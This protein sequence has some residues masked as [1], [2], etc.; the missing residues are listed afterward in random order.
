MKK[1]LSIFLIC[2]VPALV[3]HG[4]E[5]RLTLERIFSD[6]EFLPD[7]L[8]PTKWVDGGD[9][10][11]TLEPSPTHRGYVELVRYE[12][13]SGAREVL[14][15]TS[16]LVPERGEEPIYIEDYSWSEDKSRLLI[17]TNSKRVWRQNTRGEYW[18]LNLK[19]WDL[20][21]LGS[22]IRKESTLMFAKFSPDGQRVAYV[23][24]NNLYVEYVDQEKLTGLTTDGS[25]RVINGTFDWAYEEEFSCQDG[26]RWSPDGK[27]IAYWQLDAGGIRDFYMINNTDSAYSHLIPVQY[28]KVGTTNSSCRIGVVS[29]EGGSTTWMK[30][31]G[32]SRNHYIP[33]MAWAPNS[34][35]I[36]VQ[37]L[38]RAQNTNTVFLCASSNGD[39]TELYQDKE[40]TWLDVVDQFEF[41]KSGKEFTWVSQKNGWRSMYGISRSA[42]KERTITSDQFDFVSIE[43]T[44]E[45]GGW[46]YYIASPDNATQRY[47]YRSKIS[48]KGA[49]QRVTPSAQRGTHGYDI[50]P[51]GRWAIHTYSKAATPATIQLI[52]L[53]DHRPV[54]TL[55]SNDRLK[56]RVEKLAKTDVEFFTV[57]ADDGVSLDAYFMKPLD[58]DPQKK[59]PVIFHVYGEPWG[60][61]VLDSWGSLT[62]LYHLFLAQNGYVVMSVD[63]RG[64]PGPKGRAWRKSVYGQ[65]GVQSSADQAAAVREIIDRFDFVDKDR[66]GIWGWSGGGAMTLNAL[67]RYPKIYKTGIS[68]APVTNQLLYDNIY[69][70]RYS[71]L[72]SENMDG[73]IKGSPI[74]FAK[75]L[76]GNLLLIHGTGDDNVHYQNTE[77]LI[78]E[79]VRHN[80]MFMVMPYPNRSHGIYEGQN[81]TRH[82]Y[83]TMYWYLSN[84]LQPGPQ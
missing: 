64:T 67:F 71:G 10:Y 83:E 60:Q 45:E 6:F 61:T 3:A 39:V 44:D 54:R 73:Y 2:F 34:R 74:T 41:L 63:N 52:S 48:G 35:E 75:N 65:I 25:R 5:D 7:F 28:P 11:T 70:E 14:V 57:K 16:R 37:Q 12:S 81:T 18:V 43:L 32:D 79:L 53:P 15:P 82:L 77:V 17:Y 84:N 50:S 58:F 24:E 55:V 8:G 49:P 47:L 68:V 21:K 27:S 1:Y 80:K 56:N 20:R 40:E 59:Y 26:F 4:Q 76:E 69:Q 33:R 31:P 30:V 36:I 22:H 13:S 78:N 29:A 62:Y 46:V 19:S 38:N 9:G 23:S 66:I 72:P 42:G 51:N